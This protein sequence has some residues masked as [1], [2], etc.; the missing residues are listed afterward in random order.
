VYITCLQPLG[1]QALKGKMKMSVVE[2]I[3]QQAQIEQEQ[4]KRAYQVL[5]NEKVCL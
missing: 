5:Q 2:E 3:K 1:R 4:Q